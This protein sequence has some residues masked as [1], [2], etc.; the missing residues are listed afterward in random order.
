MSI[1][2]FQPPCHPRTWAASTFCQVANSSPLS[3]A[4]FIAWTRDSSFWQPW[5]DQ[6]RTAVMHQ[7]V[8]PRYPASIMKVQG[9]PNTSFLASL[10][11]HSNRTGRR[12]VEKTRLVYSQS[13]SKPSLLVPHHGFTQVLQIPVLQSDS[14][15]GENDDEMMNDDE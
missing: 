5:K 3:M 1:C 6:W 9:C 2:Y 13:S 4:V 12:K 10:A 11:A 14:S 8:D 15:R 7:W